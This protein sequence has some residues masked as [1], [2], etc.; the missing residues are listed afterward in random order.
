LSSSYALGCKRLSTTALSALDGE[1]DTNLTAEIKAKSAAIT[2]P[3]WLNK[4]KK[5]FNKE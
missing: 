2:R 1:R 5:I 3:D 4:V